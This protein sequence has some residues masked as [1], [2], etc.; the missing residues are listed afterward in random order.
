MG[1]DHEGE[2]QPTEHAAPSQRAREVYGAFLKRRGVRH[3]ARRLEAEKD[4]W[5]ETDDLL[6]ALVDNAREPIP[7]ILHDYLRRRLNGE[8]RKPQGRGRSPLFAKN[9]V[10]TLLISTFYD[11]YELYLTSRKKACGLAGWPPIRTCEW[12]QGPPSERAARMVQRK[13]QLNLSW[14]RIRD[15]AYKQRRR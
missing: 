7:E 9:R 12:W 15:I 13:L 5:I 14:E 4:R 3:L 8:A 10:R 2:S 6:A 11:R 1:R